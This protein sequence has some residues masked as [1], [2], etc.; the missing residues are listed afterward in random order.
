MRPE[1][2]AIMTA[3][4]EK[5]TENDMAEKV[6]ETEEK[7]EMKVAE[8]YSKPRRYMTSRI[9]SPGQNSAA[10]VMPASPAQQI[11]IVRL[12]ARSWVIVCAK[13]K[14]NARFYG[15][16]LIHAASF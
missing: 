14:K 7:A 9:S 6:P 5:T 1:K 4:L 11:Q 8:D 16:N 2:I 15:A 10:S 13:V 3:A 12:V